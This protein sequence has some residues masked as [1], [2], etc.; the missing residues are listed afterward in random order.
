MKKIFYC[1]VFLATAF[2]L[3]SC[4]STNKLY[5]LKNP[6]LS[7]PAQK[8][9]RICNT[10]TWV[11]N[12][13]A[14]FNDMKELLDEIGVS[15]QDLETLTFKGAYEKP[16]GRQFS[17]AVDYSDEEEEVYTAARKQ[18]RKISRLILKELAEDDSSKNATDDEE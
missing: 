10:L 4:V 6:N 17:F 8:T 12:T 2:S 15:R 14:D 1:A 5:D 13:S 18:A 16:F 3:A 7:A 9:I 11:Y